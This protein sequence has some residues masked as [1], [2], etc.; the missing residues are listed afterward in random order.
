MKIFQQLH[1]LERYIVELLRDGLRK[2]R[3]TP[4]IKIHAVIIKLE[5]VLRGPDQQVLKDFPC[6]ID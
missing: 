2:W 3:I 6:F 4:E 5:D 1:H